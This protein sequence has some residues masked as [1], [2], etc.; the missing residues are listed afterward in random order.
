MVQPV[1]MSVEG[2]AINSSNKTLHCISLS[3]VSE[4]IKASTILPNFGKM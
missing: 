3:T 1:E 4:N 2:R